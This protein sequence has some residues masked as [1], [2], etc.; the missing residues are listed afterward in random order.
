MSFLFSRRFFRLAVPGLALCLNAL[1]VSAQSLPASL[2]PPSPATPEIHG[3]RVLGVQPGHPFLFTIP[4][5]GQR[6]MTFA[7]DRLPAGLNLDPATGFVTGTAPAAGSYRVTLHAKNALGEAHRDLLIKAGKKLALTPPLGWNSWNCFNSSVTEDKIRAA[8]DAMIK[9]GLIEHGWTYIN[10]D[11]FWQVNPGRAKDDPTLGGPE[12][13]A[14]GT[15]H[16]NPRFPDMPGMAAY[17]H[18][19]GL[20]AGLYSSPGPYTCGGCTG[21]YQHEQQDAAQYAAW[22]FDYLKY[23]L[24]S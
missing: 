19:L 5:T 2:T 1:P 22:G 16:P 24:C 8:A 11:D 3:A 9:S 13:N 10:V 6:P 7:A 12:R 23:D 4:A 21:S 18:S 14:D 17:I 15:I 20:K